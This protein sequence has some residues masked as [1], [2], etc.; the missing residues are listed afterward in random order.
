MKQYL[1]RIVFVSEVSCKCSFV[2]FNMA[3]SL[4]I[5]FSFS[6]LISSALSR[7]LFFHQILTNIP[8]SMTSTIF[9]SIFGSLLLCWFVNKVLK[10]SSR[11]LHTRSTCIR[12]CRHVGCHYPLTLHLIQRSQLTSL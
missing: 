6:D 1:I 4:G 11:Y 10:P 9:L 12:P 8:P 3:P 2:T 7:A 5:S